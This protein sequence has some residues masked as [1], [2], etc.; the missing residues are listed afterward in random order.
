MAHTGAQVFTTLP[1]SAHTC[2]LVMASPIRGPST[3][4]HRGPDQPPD[5]QAE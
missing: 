5:A 4:P 1:L 3:F 2:L